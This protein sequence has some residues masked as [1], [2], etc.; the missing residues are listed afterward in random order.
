MN[1]RKPILIEVAIE[2][3]DDAVAAQ[4]GAADRLEL[5]SA[6]D[7][8]GLTPSIG[9]YLEVRAKTRLP[10]FVMIRSRG[11]DFVYSESEIAVMLRDVE[12]FLP[13]N[14]D[15]F[16]FG[17]LQPT[18]QIDVAN[19]AEFLLRVGDKPCVFHRAFDRTPD[20]REALEQIIALGF[21]RVLTSGRERLALTGSPEIAKL[22]KLAD[23]R[24]EILPCGQVRAKS[25][26]EI[27]KLTDCTQLH[28]SFAEPIPEHTGRGYR[29]YTQRCHTSESEVIATRQVLDMYSLGLD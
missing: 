28:A 5:C 19:C 2:S 3:P 21:K 24:I 14:P 17:A 27:I 8:G 6:L 23:G 26:V 22:V 13:H 1:P 4:T 18:G 20:A 16:V 7:L 25:A 15:G 9:T 29:G 11:G 10:V 12:L